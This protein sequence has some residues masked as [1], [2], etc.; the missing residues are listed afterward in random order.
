MPHEYKLDPLTAAEYGPL[1]S[2]RGSPA[3]HAKL[4]HYLAQEAQTESEKLLAKIMAAKAERKSAIAHK[5]SQLPRE[6]PEEQSQLL[7]FNILPRT[8][9]YFHPAELKAIYA[10]YPTA[11]QV[12]IRATGIQ[13]PSKRTILNFQENIETTYPEIIADAR[14]DIGG[15]EALPVPPGGHPLNESERAH[16]REAARVRE[17]IKKRE[18]QIPQPPGGHPLDESEVGHIREAARVREAL[19]GKG[20][21]PSRAPHARPSF[22]ITTEEKEIIRGRQPMVGSLSPL[23]ES[24][25]EQIAA[26]VRLGRHHAHPLLPRIPTSPSQ[27]ARLE[28][29]S[30]RAHSALR[31]PVIP[32]ITH[33][34]SAIAIPSLKGTTPRVARAILE[35]SDVRKSSETFLSPAQ[36]QKL[37]R[38]LDT[39]RKEE[40]IDQ[41]FGN[42]ARLQPEHR[43]SEE[44]LRESI[45]EGKEA[46]E[47]AAQKLEK[48]REDERFPSGQKFL[49]LFQKGPEGWEPEERR[50][51]RISR[52]MRPEATTQEIER[53]ERRANKEWEEKI[54][55]ELSGY[56]SMIHPRGSGAHAHA[57]TKAR[58]EHFEKLRDHIDILKERAYEKALAHAN[59]EE[60]MALRGA[61]TQA[62]LSHHKRSHAHAAEELAFRQQALNQTRDQAAMSA[63][64]QLAAQKQAQHQTEM[65]ERR[66][67][68]EEELHRPQYL[69]ERKAALAQGL[70]PPTFESSLSP[71][72]ATFRPPAS[73][74]ALAAGILGTVGPSLIPAVASAL[75]GG[76][77]AHGGPIKAKKLAE[78][79]MPKWKE[80]ADQMEEDKYLKHQEELASHFKKP[81][82][83]NPLLHWVGEAGRGLLSNISHPQP[84]NLLGEAATRTHKAQQEHNEYED[85]KRGVAFEL[86]DKMRQSLHD[87]KK[88]LANYELKREGLEEGKRHHRSME[89]E[90]SRHHRM[91]ELLGSQRVAAKPTFSEK[92][93]ERIVK[94]KEN[95]KEGLRLKEML[96]ELREVYSDLDT[97]PKLGYLAENGWDTIASKVGGVGDVDKIQRARTLTNEF[98]REVQEMGKRGGRSN[99]AL[100]LIQSGKMNFYNTKKVN[101]STIN[102]YEKGIDFSIN[103]NAHVLHN[104][105]G[106]PKEEIQEYMEEISPHDSKE[107]HPLTFGH[108]DNPKDF[109]DKE[110]DHI[111]SKGR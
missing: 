9:I 65:N 108:S 79:G 81:T 70:N 48:L 53:L 83:F 14:S 51:T 72:I 106:L 29:L 77:A 23:D 90:Q 38:R 93:K 8:E 30:R 27:R 88:F 59:L 101:L 40:D 102:Q 92:D 76:S 69:L 12:Y 84:L 26:A 33:A 19:K 44:L 35:P 49:D 11:R 2:L 58:L 31:T 86:Y 85:K 17:A 57:L 10:S 28:E 71:S 37:F 25:R 39:L 111:I 62:S 110:I 18:M 36:R 5:K 1:L 66:R 47:H 52:H 75:T 100:R 24:E 22:P 50:Q 46:K 60:Q 99:M 82:E 96:K 87:Q 67:Q 7:P 34:P 80:L 6:T 45:R 61:E 94:A 13:N 103:H 91:A 89:E 43:E 16:L 15:R 73:G 56:W 20:L 42:I 3:W 95:L 21:L 74:A 63:M 97:G 105:I 41:Q 107:D 4:Q 55:P 32:P 78:G 54:A 68:E 64:S 98:V 104:E 109:S